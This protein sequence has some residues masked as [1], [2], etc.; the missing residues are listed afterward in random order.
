MF[1]IHIFFLVIVFADFSQIGATRW[2]VWKNFAS[3]HSFKTN[4]FNEKKAQVFWLTKMFTANNYYYSWP[5]SIFLFRFL[6]MKEIWCLLELWST[7][8]SRIAEN[9]GGSITCL[10]LLQNWGNLCQ[11]IHLIRNCPKMKFYVWP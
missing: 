4:N 3:S 11:R 7:K 5:D 6:Q 2:N 10:V 8:C 9:D 1:H